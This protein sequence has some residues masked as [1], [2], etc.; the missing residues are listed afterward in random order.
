MPVI[1]HLCYQPF[2]ARPS[3]IES[4]LLAKL[5]FPKGILVL[6]NNSTPLLPSPVVFL[7][8]SRFPPVFFASPEDYG[9][10]SEDGNARR[11]LWRPDGHD[12]GTM[13]DHVLKPF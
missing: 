6:P 8:F 3:H 13:G 7:V 2:Q 9:L 4:T 1:R 5:F 11:A 10:P 12:Q